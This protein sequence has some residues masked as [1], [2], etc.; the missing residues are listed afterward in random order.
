MPVFVGPYSQRGHGLG[1]ILGSVGKMAIPLLKQFAKTGARVALST[2]ANLMGDLFKGKNLKASLKSRGGEA[3]KRTG[4]HALK[5]AAQALSGNR[6]Q[7]PRAT[8]STRGRRVKKRRSSPGGT[9]QSRK[10]KQVKSR[11]GKRAKIA[12]GFG[13][14][15]G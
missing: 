3:V 13:D 7:T 11:G 1:G 14:I 2:G 6:R 8:T 9:A 10:N 5:L 4:L 15:F 12:S